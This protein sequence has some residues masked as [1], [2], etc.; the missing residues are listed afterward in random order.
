MYATA[1][2][3]PPYLEGVGIMRECA[4]VQRG[5]LDELFA[6]R[7]AYVAKMMRLDNIF[8]G[9]LSGKR[10]LAVN[11]MEFFTKPM[12]GSRTFIVNPR[13]VHIAKNGD[14]P[15]PAGESNVMRGTVR[16]MRRRTQ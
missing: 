15:F 4:I 14:P 12:N 1:S 11:G 16:E 5:I 8:T 10:Q 9:G 7:S 3:K 2:T 6:G 13:L